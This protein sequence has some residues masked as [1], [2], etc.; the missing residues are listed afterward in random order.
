MPTIHGTEANGQ[1]G[2]RATSAGS[3]HGPCKLDVV[4]R[5]GSRRD[6]GPARGGITRSFVHVGPLFYP[7]SARPCGCIGNSPEARP[8]VFWLSISP[9]GASPLAAACQRH[10]SRPLRSNQ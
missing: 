1:L 10:S 4:P 9:I 2:A 6:T 3:D 8:V 5:R 7:A